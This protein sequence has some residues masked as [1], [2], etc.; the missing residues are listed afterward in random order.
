MRATSSSP[1]ILNVP[2]AEADTA[3]AMTTPPPP[4]PSGT[5]WVDPPPASMGEAVAA[6]A[7]RLAAAGVEGARAEARRL[8]EASAGV[9]RERLLA[10]PE[11]PLTPEAAAVF[12]RAVGRR[13]AREP[14]A[15]VAGR[16]EFHGR[17]FAVGPGVLV[18]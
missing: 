16:R 14:F 3:A 15:Y 1:P 9:S 7:G 5:S 4:E 6:A 12:A 11:A 13:A 8:L 17:E 18:P 10:A 2:A